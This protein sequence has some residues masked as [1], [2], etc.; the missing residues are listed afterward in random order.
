MLRKS[1]DVYF[2]QKIKPKWDNF[3]LSNFVKSTLA[4]WV[5]SQKKMT[6]F[7]RRWR[8][9]LLHINKSFH[10]LET[11]LHLISSAFRHFAT[12][13]MWRIRGN[14]FCPRN[15]LSAKWKAWTEVEA[16]KTKRRKNRVALM[17]LSNAI[18][19]L[20]VASQN[21]EAVE[22]FVRW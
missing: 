3:E 21:D 11:R 1:S 20:P 15:D 2:Y 7:P 17:L 6:Q 13:E 16:Q 18:M 22:W 14:T 12:A 9:A 8:Q 5:N 10:M 19:R 4:V